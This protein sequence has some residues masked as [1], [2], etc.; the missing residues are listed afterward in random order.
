MRVK[1][2]QLKAFGR[3]LIP[4]S[5]VE[6]FGSQKI[7]SQ[8]VTHALYNALEGHAGDLTAHLFAQWKLF[9][10]ETAGADASA[11]LWEL[12]EKELREIQASLEEV[13]E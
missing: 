7:L 1:E 8:Q 6:N 12:T 11:W 5:P 4:E 2:L 9:F 3:A 13:L 10:G